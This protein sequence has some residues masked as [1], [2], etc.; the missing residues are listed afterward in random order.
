[1][2]HLINRIR[3]ALARTYHPAAVRA[4]WKVGR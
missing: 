3:W 2:R 4:T 1:M